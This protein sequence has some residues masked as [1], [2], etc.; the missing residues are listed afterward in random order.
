MPKKKGVG[1]PLKIHT[2]PFESGM[3]LK[4]D[5]LTRCENTIRLH[6]IIDQIAAALV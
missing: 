3:G 5:A 4:G 1:S 6:Y 2:R